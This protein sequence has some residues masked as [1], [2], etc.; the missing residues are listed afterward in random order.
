MKP[1]NMAGYLQALTKII[2]A[3]DKTGGDMNPDFTKLRQAIDDNKV[4]DLDETALTDI[5]ATFQTGTDAYVDNLNK[6]QQ[7]SVPVRILGKHK[8]L[9]A[10]YRNYS[11]ACQNMV[12]A[13]DPATQK[14]DV[15]AFDQSEKEQENMMEKVTSATQ[16]I[17]S[18]VM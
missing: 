17:M 4:T 5:K 10:A 9:V 6:L 1:N 13:I 16:R 15:D 14:I 8:Q 7:A 3:T 18:S 2:E 11:E 12:N